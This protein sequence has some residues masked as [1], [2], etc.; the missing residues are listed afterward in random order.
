MAAEDTPEQGSVQEPPPNAPPTA[1]PAV[2]QVNHFQVLAAAQELLNLTEDFVIAL[3]GEGPVVTKRGGLHVGATSNTQNYTIC[4]V[5]RARNG[6]QK[7][8]KHSI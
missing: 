8:Q 7:H 5:S 4:R 1:M 3:P 6:M 2:A